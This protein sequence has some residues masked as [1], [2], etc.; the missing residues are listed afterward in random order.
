M[1][2]QVIGRVLDPP[3]IDYKAS[4][5]QLVQGG[6]WR[7]QKGRTKLAEGSE[8]KSYAIVASVPQ[9]RAGQVMTAIVDILK[10]CSDLG[11]SAN[12]SRPS[13]THSVSPL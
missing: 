11:Q 8:V 2:N 7:M 12:R 5:M 13:A 9:N 1:Q 6:V 10:G 3:A 4:G